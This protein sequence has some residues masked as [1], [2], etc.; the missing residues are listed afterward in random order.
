MDELLIVAALR[1]YRLRFG[2]EKQLQ[3]D[4][5][6]VLRTEGIEFAREHFLG[7][8]RID[9]FCDGVG[10]ECKVQDGPAKVLQQLVGYAAEETVTAILLVTSRRTHRFSQTA[11]LGKPLIVVWIAG[12]SI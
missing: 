5:E 7:T 9:F 3:D 2:S 4:V 11:I 1:S 8:D 6:R 12:N 10:I